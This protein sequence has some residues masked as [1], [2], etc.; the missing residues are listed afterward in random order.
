MQFFKLGLFW[1]EIKSHSN[2]NTNN[3][4]KKLVIWMILSGN[5][6]PTI[7]LSDLIS[8]L[9]LPTQ[10]LFGLCSSHFWISVQGVPSARGLGWIDLDFECSTVGP[11]LPGIMGIWQKWLGSWARWWNIKVLTR[12]HEQMGHPT[13]W[14]LVHEVRIRTTRA[15]MLKSACA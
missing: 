2:P 10:W 7:G 4:T 8:E 1:V 3:N 14:W 13:L 5:W 9:F 12:V 6:R 11:I 15:V